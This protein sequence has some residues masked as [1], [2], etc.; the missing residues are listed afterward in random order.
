[1]P[2]A[3]AYTGKMVYTTEDIDAMLRGGSLSGGGSGAAGLSIGTAPAESWTASGDRWYCDLA[4]GR[5]RAMIF[6]VA[7]DTVGDAGNNP[8]ETSIDQ[9]EFVDLNTTRIWLS[10]NP[11]ADRIIFFYI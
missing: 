9:K 3:A 7:Y 6:V 4:H 8:M 5:K 2:V 1:M 10:W 11:G